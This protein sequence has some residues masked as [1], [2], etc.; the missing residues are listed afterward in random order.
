MRTSIAT[1]LILPTTHRPLCAGNLFGQESP[2]DR[3]A[4]LTIA[5]GDL[6]KIPVEYDGEVLNSLSNVV[7]LGELSQDQLL[8]DV[9]EDVLSKQKQYDV[10]TAI[11]DKQTEL[12][13][14]VFAGSVGAA[15]L[16]SIRADFNNDEI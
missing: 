16:N 8:H 10:Y 13:S 1:M 15:R 12:L 14:Q 3:R 6:T 7:L 4:K 9:L 2:D 11:I 5:L